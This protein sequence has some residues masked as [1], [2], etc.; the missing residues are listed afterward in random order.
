MW[1]RMACYRASFVPICVVL[2]AFLV[3]GAFVFRFSSVT[4]ATAAPC[5]GRC[6]GASG[7]SARAPDPVKPSGESID[8]LIP[9]LMERARAGLLDAVAQRM[10]AEELARR[11]DGERLAALF[12]ELE[13]CI[14][15][16]YLV[17]LDYACGLSILKDPAAEAWYRRALERR[18]NDSIAAIAEYS[19]WLLERG[20]PADALRVLSLQEP[21]RR[22]RGLH[23]YRAVALEML[24]QRAAAE[25]HYRA[26]LDFNRAFPAPAALRTPGGVAAGVRYDDAPGVLDT[27]SDARLKLSQMVYCEARGESSGGQAAVAWT[28]RNRVFVYNP[29]PGCNKQP[30]SGTYCERYLTVLQS[31]E[32]CTGTSHNSDTDATADCVFYGWIPDPVA[33]RCALGPLLEGTWCDGACKYGSETGGFSTGGYFFYSTTGSC[34]STHPSGCGVSRGKVCGNG[35]YDHCFYSVQ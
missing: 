26:Y 9:Y 10:V 7:P 16:S 24:G 30:A 25:D 35:G 13:R 14:P 15:G 11:G 23:F 1:R 20:R 32:F 22:F 31:G 12:G 34:A 17:A 27:C 3:A 29:S 19:Q 4:T 6:P 28:A 2:V 21:G 5:G 18:P 33:Q 8:A